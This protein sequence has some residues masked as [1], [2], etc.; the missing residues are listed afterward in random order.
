[1]DPAS[2]NYRRFV[3]HRQLTAAE[4]F[5]SLTLTGVFQSYVMCQQQISHWE[6]KG[7]PS[8]FWVMKGE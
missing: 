8:L 1:M 5:M 6:C 3:A 4:S 2:V 7:I